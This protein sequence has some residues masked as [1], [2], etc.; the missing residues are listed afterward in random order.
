[1]NVK[2]KVQAK[3]SLS[4]PRRHIGRAEVSLH[5]FLPSALS[6]QIHTLT[7]LPL[8]TQQEA[9]G[10]LQSVSTFWTTEKSLAL[11]G[12]EVQFIQSTA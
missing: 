10:A 11:P 2:L 9:G 5:S 6:G 1:M 8:S 12:I 7:A 4:T 3:F